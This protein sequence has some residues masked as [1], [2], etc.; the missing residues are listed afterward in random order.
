MGIY[1]TA[2]IFP[3]F[4]SIVNVMRIKNKCAVECIGAEEVNSDLENYLNR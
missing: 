4:Q 3:Y 2:S 1:R